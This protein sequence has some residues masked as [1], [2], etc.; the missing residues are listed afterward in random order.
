MSTTCLTLET[1]VLAASGF[2][3]TQDMPAQLPALKL[4]VAVNLACLR[5]FPRIIPM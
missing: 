2:S 4:E 3:A 5:A 1:A